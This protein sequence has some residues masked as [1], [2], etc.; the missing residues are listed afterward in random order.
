MTT[1][2]RWAKNVVLSPDT[3][4]CWG[5]AGGHTK[6]GYGVTSFTHAGRKRIYAHCYSYDRFVG[7]QPKGMDIDHLCRNRGCV[8]PAH[9]ELV[10][11]SEN[12]RRGVGVGKSKLN[13]K[14]CPQ[15]HPY[16]GGNL[17]IAPST[18]GRV[19]LT[20]NRAHTKRYR[21][22]AKEERRS[23]QCSG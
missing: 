4:G 5:W 8:N 10:T 13:N 17:Y 23:N 1:M 3:D 16:S 18:G 14:C 7:E 22:A 2:Q 12:L 6:S 19:C 11:R 20:C 9:L 21:E 15:G